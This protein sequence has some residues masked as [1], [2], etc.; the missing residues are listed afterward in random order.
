MSTQHQASCDCGWTGGPYRSQGQAAYALRQHSCDAQRR[1][2]EN[3][4]RNKTRLAR[5]AQIDRTP[6]ACPHPIHHQHGTYVAYTLDHC[7]CTDCATASAAYERAR[8]RRNA[9]GRSN[10]TDATPVRE[11]IATLTAAG[12]GLKQITRHTGING[13][14]MS[15]LVYGIPGQRPPSRRVLKTTAA[16]ILALNPNDPSLVADGARIDAT[17]TRRRLQA[18]GTLG[19]SIQ[20]LA[21]IAQ[22][23]RQ[24]LDG[25]MRGRPVQGD[26]R[27]AV[28]TLYE[29][30]WNVPAPTTTKGAKISAA[31]AQGRA[32]REG[33]APPLAWDDETIDDPAATPYVDEP[34]DITRPGQGRVNADSLHDCAIDWG[35]TMQQAADRLHVS[36][37]TVDIAIRR[38]D[39][40]AAADEIRAAFHRNTIAQGHDRP[41]R[42]GLGLRRTA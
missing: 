9:Y 35:L 42:D 7:R 3:A 29:H 4:A 15:K 6:K 34:I 24:R 13:G 40:R 22:L 26:T 32:Q 38:L 41:T 17:G 2:D 23:D 5:L 19:W 8:V 28:T 12:I 14:V 37:S 30:L 11:H 10:L 20:S 16:K 27:R 33:W 18:L 39:D 25:A 21:L 1:R 31:R 36:R